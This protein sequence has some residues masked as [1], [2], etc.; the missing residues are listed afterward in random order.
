M[1]TARQIREA[2]EDIAAEHLDL[3]TLETRNWDHYDF[4]EHAVWDIKQALEAAF[5]LGATIGKANR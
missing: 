3:T 4:H 2:L 5:E 1:T